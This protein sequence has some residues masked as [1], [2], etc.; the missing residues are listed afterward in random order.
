MKLRRHSAKKK[1]I[2]YLVILY[3]ACYAINEITTLRNIILH[4]R[5]LL[6]NACLIN[7]KKQ[8]ERTQID[9]HFNL[10]R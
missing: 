9:R 6:W 4:I 3:A 8:Y 2:L 5:P 10:N 1:K 7:T